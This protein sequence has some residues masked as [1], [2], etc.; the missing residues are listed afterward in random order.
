MASDADDPEI[1]Y[2]YTTMD[3]MINMVETGSIWATSIS[4][5]NDVSEGEHF[6]KLICERLPEYRQTH[7]LEDDSIF[8]GIREKSD[9]AFKDRSF[10]LGF[11]GR[12]SVA[13]FS[14][15]ADSLPQWRSYCPNGNGVAVGFRVECLQRAFVGLKNDPN[16]SGGP[17]VTFGPVKYIDSSDVQ[18]FDNAIG[19][20]IQAATLLAQ[21][22][23]QRQGEFPP[24]DYF[25]YIIERQAC[26]KKHPSFSN[27]R[28]YRL[29]VDPVLGNDKW[30][31]F[32]TSR[33]T[34]VPY[35][36]VSIPREH[37]RYT[38][39]TTNLTP[40]TLYSPLA[41]RWQFIDR[42]VIGPTTNTTLS[43]QAFN[44]FFQKHSLHVQVVPS[45][46]PYRDW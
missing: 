25:K 37:S 32:R 12:P 40:S 13:S 9:V 2:H 44:S 7:K 4:Y 24:K 6:L 3:A 38:G 31:E 35:V 33:S 43:I 16:I 29:I 17:R 34:L 8:D 41:G 36:S 10:G 19:T 14:Q 28:E 5:L 1:V 45:N 27:E 26:F 22:P 11:K 46:V 23:A 18:S 15:E 39:A 42:V 21:H 20:A 30:L